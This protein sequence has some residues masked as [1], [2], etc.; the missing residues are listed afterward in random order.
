MR[1]F[2][3]MAIDWPAA[4]RSYQ[5]LPADHYHRHVRVHH[6]DKD[7]DDPLLR[8]VLSQRPDGPSRG[9]RR[10]GVTS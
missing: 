9:R 7:K 3:D 8:D 2:P 1:A 6:V 5:N 4:S 10:R